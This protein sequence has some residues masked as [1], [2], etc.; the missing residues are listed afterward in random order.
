VLD[1]YQAEVRRREEA[2]QRASQGEGETEDEM[3]SS[4]ESAAAAGDVTVLAWDVMAPQHVTANAPQAD[5]DVTGPI[6]ERLEQRLSLAGAATP[7]SGRSSSSGG[8]AEAEPAKKQLSQAE[9]SQLAVE[10]LRVMVPRQTDGSHQYI[11]AVMERFD[12]EY[13]LQKKNTG[14]GAEV[15]TSRHRSS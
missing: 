4:Q 14:A 5:S 11:A 15:C 9:Q 10:E 7:A 3:T 6:R 1:E 13:H 2:Q 12:A 8:S